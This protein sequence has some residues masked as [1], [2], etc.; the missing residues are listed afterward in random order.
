MLANGN[1][2]A[3]ASAISSWSNPSAPLGTTDNGWL[4]RTAGLG[5]NF[6]VANPQFSAVNVQG[7][8]GYTNY[9]S[10]QAQVTLR[11]TAGV[12]LSSSYTWSKN[13]GISGS[14]PTDP[15]DFDADYTVTGNDRRHV[16]TS[17]GTFDLPFGPKGLFLK[18]AHGLASRSSKA[19]R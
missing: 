8:R 7:N 3:L 12:S 2:S 13:L 5:E 9:H 6:V 18:S 4:L 19:G 16:F 1:Y 15:R 11:P 17:Y 14:S 10:L